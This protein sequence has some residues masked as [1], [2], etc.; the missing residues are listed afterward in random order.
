MRNALA[1]LVLVTAAATAHASDRDR[2]HP[3]EREQPEPRPCKCA[4]IRPHVSLELVGEA[5]DTFPAAVLSQVK[6][7]EGAI[8][9]CIG[10][11]RDTKLE[12]AFKRHATTPRISVSGSA[13]VK[14][15][16]ERIS[17]G[18]F[19]AAP[20]ATTIAISASISFRRG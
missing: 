5:R 4:R 16:L 2:E 6:R 13:A 17:W 14:S 18:G 11:A 20:R 10:P 15:C 3:A 19:A 9:R 7:S 1:L 8:G 12:L